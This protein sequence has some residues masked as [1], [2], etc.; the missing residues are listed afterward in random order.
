FSKNKR[1]KNIRKLD[2]RNEEV[3]RN[4][5]E[6][7]NQFLMEAGLNDVVLM[8]F[9]GHGVLDKD[10]NYYLATYEMDIE[11]MA[12]TCIPFSFF[13]QLLDKMQCRNKLMF[14]DAC[15]SGEL[16]KDALI[17]Y[18]DKKAK[19]V[20]EKNTR[21]AGTGVSYNEILDY[22]G[23]SQSFVNTNSFDLS[24]LLF[25][26]MRLSNGA[27]ILSSASGLEY[28]LES[29]AWGN[30]LFT[31]ALIK[32]IS[33][34]EAD[35]NGDGRITIF[36]LR[37]YLRGEVSSISRGKQNPISRKENLKNNFIIW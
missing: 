9:A 25:T 3:S 24:T 12:S 17:A 8:F 37:V 30:G 10:Y 13:E 29:Q 1:Y 2:L 11:D 19:Q 7:I 18:R 27:N 23:N 34:F 14:I 26:D 20:D 28:A 6:E 15:H 21:A 32:G 16:D 4:K 36:E 31:Y 5:M 33:D 22:R 35:L